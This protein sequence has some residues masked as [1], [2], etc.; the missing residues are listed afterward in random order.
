MG[1]GNTVATT[2]TPW[3][4]TSQTLGS[5]SNNYYYNNYD[6]GQ[7]GEAAIDLTALGIDP[8]LLAG[9]NPC[10]PPFTRILFKSRSSSS[11]TSALQDFAGPYEFLDAPVPSSAIG[12]VSKLTCV[13]T[14]VTLSPQTYIEGNYYKWTTS[15]GS[16]SGNPESSSI[17]VTQPG[18][19][20]FQSAAYKGCTTTTDSIIV[21]QDTFKPIAS[22]YVSNML[23]IA[24][25]TAILLG[26]DTSASKYNNTSGIY[27]GLTWS[28]TGPNGFSSG[29]QNPVTNQSGLYKLIVSQNSNGC[30]DSAKTNVLDELQ[31]GVLSVNNLV[32]TATK[33]NASKIKINW[34]VTGESINSFEVYRSTDGNIFKSIATIIPDAAA[35]IKRN[36]YSDDVSTLNSI[37]VFYKLKWT[38]KSG[39]INYSGIKK[40]GLT[41]NMNIQTMPNPF[42]DKLNVNFLSEGGGTCEVRLITTSGNLIKTATSTIKKGYNSIELRDLHFPGI[43]SIYS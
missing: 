22:A 2:A 12:S 16:I 7:F 43:W 40:I 15:N 17:T 8:V 6:F 29:D 37:N 10:A 33:D 30:V 4:T 25:P 31:A 5:S 19:Y 39:K 32:F 41:E 13:N 3:G 34:A 36:D 24:T 9:N 38:D 14:S 42:I 1:I 18:K 20:Y 35:I 27:Q 28:W 26:G 23:S 11:F 21:S